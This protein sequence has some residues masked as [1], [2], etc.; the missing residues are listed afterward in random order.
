MS[1]GD[2]P[3][4][5][6]SKI[7]L[8]PVVKAAEQSIAK[9]YDAAVEAMSADAAALLAKNGASNP[10]PAKD[11]KTLTA[12]MIARLE[13][14]LRTVFPKADTKADEPPSDPEKP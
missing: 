3:Q 5:D 8:A 14:N 6:V 10:P 13:A 4:P 2:P 1:N 9:L 7:P 11:L 12:D